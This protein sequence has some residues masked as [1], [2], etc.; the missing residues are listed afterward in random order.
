MKTYIDYYSAVHWT[1]SSLILF[2]D[3]HK[4]DPDFYVET[5]P[6]EEGN[7]PEI[8]QY[9]LTAL[10]D[11][12]VEWMKK[13]FPDVIL[14]YSNKLGLWV[15]CVDHYGTSWGYVWTEVSENLTK[16]YSDNFFNEKGEGTITL[17]RNITAKFM[18]TKEKNH[19]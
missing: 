8:Y 12:D 6:D 9:F 2:N 19:D 16:Y 18:R 15:L 4:I 11:E 1:N 17:Q 10:N 3:I 7:Y 14:A 13:T 5:E